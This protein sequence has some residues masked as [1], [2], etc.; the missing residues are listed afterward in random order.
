MA[1]CVPVMGRTLPPGTAPAP[2][3]YLLMLMPVQQS[4]A[5]TEVPA[6]ARPG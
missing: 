6:G 2:C 1:G 4:L 3:E 5:R